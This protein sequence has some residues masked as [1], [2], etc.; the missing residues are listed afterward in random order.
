MLRRRGV[1]GGEEC[2]AKGEGEVSMSMFA[3][4]FVRNFSNSGLWALFDS[5]GEVDFL[6][7]LGVEISVLC[8]CC[9]VPDRVTYLGSCCGKEMLA[10]SDLASGCRGSHL[11]RHMVSL[12]RSFF[13]SP[14]PLMFPA[15]IHTHNLVP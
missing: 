7:C 8:S 6:P 15:K 11:E 1:I 5:V 4:V 3:T 14:T 9:K 2:E 12:Q 10:G 13:H